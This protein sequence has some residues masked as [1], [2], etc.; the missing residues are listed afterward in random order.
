[1]NQDLD[2][3]LEELSQASQTHGGLKMVCE[4]SATLY[5]TI[6]NLRT[7]RRASAATIQRLATYFRKEAKKRERRAL[8][9]KT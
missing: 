2:Y 6:Y 1:M 3:V 9:E 7:K 5:M 8:K 4:E